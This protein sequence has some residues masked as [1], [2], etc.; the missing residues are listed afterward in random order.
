MWNNGWRNSGCF[1][2]P[3]AIVVF[4]YENWIAQ[5]PN[6]NYLSSVQATMYFDIATNYFRND[7]FGPVCNLDQKTLILY[8]LTAHIAQLFAPKS[9][10]QNPSTIVGR[11]NT[12]SE[13]SVSV[14]AEFQASPA[15]SW[16]LQTQYGASAWQ[17]MLPWRTM[18]YVP[19]VSRIMNPWP[20]Q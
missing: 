10:G 18:R 13:G 15:A 19:G 3:S 17:L 11:I 14:G 1:G 20:F 5:F 9:N 8:L 4:N 12:A 2:Q 7:G 6:F 16:Y